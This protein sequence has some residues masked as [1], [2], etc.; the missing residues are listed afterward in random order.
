[1]H[2]YVGFEQ[3]NIHF[4]RIFNR[5]NHILIS[6]PLFSPLHSLSPTQWSNI[7]R[8]MSCEWIITLGTR[9]GGGGIVL[10]ENIPL[11]RIPPRLRL[12]S[13]P[14][15]CMRSNKFVVGPVWRVPIDAL[16]ESGRRAA[17][18]QH[19]STWDPESYRIVT[20]DESER[21]C[22]SRVRRN[23]PRTEVAFAYSRK[24]RTLGK[25]EWALSSARTDVHVVG[26][27]LENVSRSSSNGYSEEGFGRAERSTCPGLPR[28]A[29]SDSP[30][31]QGT[32]E[33]KS[34]DEW[35][36]RKKN[37]GKKDTKKIRVLRVKEADAENSNETHCPTPGDAS[38]IHRILVYDFR[39]ATP[40]G[41]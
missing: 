9:S 40:G 30:R 23:E 14:S 6:V 26:T 20:R 12:F 15:Y 28:P 5:F 17:P 3:L 4:N 35:R 33:N 27:I 39:R 31:C 32:S 29:R 24:D 2:S 11:S 19:G 7:L 41:K 36:R 10:S 37:E 22:F 18:A 21:P 16:C 1:M 34:E 25:R 8:C 38:E 13:F